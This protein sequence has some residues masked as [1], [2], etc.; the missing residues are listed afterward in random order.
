M[1]CRDE[2]WVFRGRLSFHGQVAS[3]RF[4]CLGMTVCAVFSMVSEHSVVSTI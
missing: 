3:V 1:N 4:V 2:E